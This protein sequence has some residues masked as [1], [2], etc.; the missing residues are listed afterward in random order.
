MNATLQLPRSNTRNIAHKGRYLIVDD[1][2]SSSL[3][4]QAILESEGLRVDIAKNEEEMMDILA[5]Y[6]FDALFLDYKLGKSNGLHLIP[7]ILRE[8]PFCR[9]IMITAHGS[10]DLAVDAMKKGVSGFITKP[11]DEIKVLNEIKHSFCKTITAQ[12]PNEWNDDTGIVGK[13]PQITRIHE[14]I[15]KMKN[16]DSTVLILGE[17]GTGKELVARALHQLSKRSKN[18]F[19]AINCAAIPENLLEVELFGCKKGAFTDAKS[20][21]KGLFEICSD[22]TL[23]LD[24]IGEMPIHLQSKLLRVLQEKEISPLGS[25]RT[26]QLKTRVVAAT[27]QNLD[28]LVREGKFRKDLFYRL[29]ILQISMPP[30]R[31]RKEDIELLVNYFVDK[32]CH[33]FDKKVTKINEDLL[34]RI[35]SY[36]WPGNVR[37]LYNSLERA[38]VLSEGDQLNADDVFFHIKQQNEDIPSLDHSHFKSLNEAKEEFEKL[39]LERLLEATKGNVSHAAKI[40]KRLRTDMYRLFGKYN[41]DPSS[42]KP[43]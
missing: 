36:E 1:E 26:V 39:Y 32:L 15:H 16:V 40:A 20:D 14:Q 11:F 27:N 29:S 30:L 35:C 5:R 17:S 10:I 41:I 37:E 9:I 33:Q 8:F 21:R 42:F 13:S 31:D 6:S 19:E 25:T 22:G 2:K 28:R 4:L 7:R 43:K 38:V 24:E 3:I 23:F 18:R 12:T 34:I